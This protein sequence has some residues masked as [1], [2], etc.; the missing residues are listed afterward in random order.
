MS[1]SYWKPDTQTFLFLIRD[2]LFFAR[3]ES[4]ATHKDTENTKQQN[5]EYKGKQ[6]PVVTKRP[7]RFFLQ[8]FLVAD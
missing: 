6:T 8:N 3:F 5:F 1:F 2:I 7:H 4:K